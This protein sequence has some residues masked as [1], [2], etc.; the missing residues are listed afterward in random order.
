MIKVSSL[1]QSCKGLDCYRTRLDPLQMASTDLICHRNLL[2]SSAVSTFSILAK[3]AN[4][5]FGTFDTSSM[6]FPTVVCFFC[7]CLFGLPTQGCPG[8]RSVPTP[9][10]LQASLCSLPQHLLLSLSLTHPK[11]LASQGLL[12]PAHNAS[13][14]SLSYAAILSPLEALTHA[15]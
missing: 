5:C 9:Q 13:V 1:L 11:C 15:P 4:Y 6:L 10:V 7:Y 3:G 8:Q 12:S 2:S 14:P